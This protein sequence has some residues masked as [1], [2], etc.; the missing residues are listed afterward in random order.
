MTVARHFL[1]ARREDTHSTASA[2][3]AHR[4]LER[5][6]MPQRV[7]GHSQSKI[8]GLHGQ[9]TT[10]REYAIA[11]WGAACAQLFLLALLLPLSPCNC[12]PCPTFPRIKGV[13]HTRAAVEARLL[14]QAED[15]HFSVEKFVRAP[16]GRPARD[17]LRDGPAGG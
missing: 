11:T 10:R 15:Y 12:N 5:L 4:E 17:A 2:A 13:G 1:G 7:R 9:A 16:H 3:V 14:R 8:I 6:A